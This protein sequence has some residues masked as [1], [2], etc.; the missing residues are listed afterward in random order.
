MFLVPSVVNISVVPLAPP[1]FPSN[2]TEVNRTTCACFLRWTSLYIRPM[3]VQEINYML[4]IGTYSSYQKS[5]WMTLTGLSLDQLWSQYTYE[6][7]KSSIKYSIDGPLNLMRC[8][9]GS[10]SASVHSLTWS[11][12]P[13]TF[14]W[15]VSVL[16]GTLYPQIDYS[17]LNFTTTSTF[18]IDGAFTQTMTMPLTLKVQA[19]ATVGSFSEILDT[20]IIVSPKVEAVL[21]NFS[22]S[23]TFNSSIGIQIY[24][25]V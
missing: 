20:Q 3:I 6:A 14:D 24:P 16:N 18:A 2:Y 19:K 23:Y 11:N 1:E 22:S 7:I 21:T 12:L 13:I 9:G 8:E 5:S 10:V 4:S 25:E 15:N 17:I